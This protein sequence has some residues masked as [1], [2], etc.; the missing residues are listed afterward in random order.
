MP[1]PWCVQFMQRNS[2]ATLIFS[3]SLWSSISDARESLIQAKTL[4]TQP[5]DPRGSVVVITCELMFHPNVGSDETTGPKGTWRLI[6][7]S[8]RDCWVCRI[9]IV[10]RRYQ[11]R[12]IRHPEGVRCGSASNLG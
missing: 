2:R 11:S 5:T 8:L 10:D 9:N 6:G 4:K 1:H 12:S 3:S 7:R